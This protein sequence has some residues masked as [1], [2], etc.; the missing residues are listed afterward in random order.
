M[1]DVDL[2]EG[3][4]ATAGGRRLLALLQGPAA[5]RASSRSAFSGAL[6]GVAVTGE[7]LV[8]LRD[9]RTPAVVDLRWEGAPRELVRE[10][11]RRA[12]GGASH[13]RAQGA[14]G[15]VLDA[16]PAVAVRAHP[17]APAP[18]RGVRADP[19]LTVLTAALP[20]AGPVDDPGGDLAARRVR[21]ADPAVLDRR[22]EA[23][24]DLARLAVRPGWSLTPDAA[25]ALRAARADGA[26]ATARTTA[27]GVPLADLF[28]APADEAVRALE[29]LRDLAPDVPLGPGVV[30][31]VAALRTA[32]GRPA[33]GLDDVLHALAPDA[34]PA[35]RRA[36]AAAA[37][38]RR[39]RAPVRGRVPG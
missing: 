22:P 14:V 34:T 31:D 16:P 7:A 5:E 21:L 19:A 23:V 33:P 3:L 13:R 36:F 27:L 32:L 17:A 15:L 28:D 20:L 9:G 12:R 25:A 18:G 37:F 11:G 29:L 2:R 26:P 38:L 35:R 8:A 10:L 24:L 4:G 6:P 1:R 30:V 39:P